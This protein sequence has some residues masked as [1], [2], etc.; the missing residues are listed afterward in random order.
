MAKKMHQAAQG[1]TFLT[2]CNIA[3]MPVMEET[4]VAVPQEPPEE[5]TVMMML[6]DINHMSQRSKENYDDLEAIRRM[7]NST[8]HNVNHHIDTVSGL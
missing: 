3:D 4:Q 2:G 5:R 6:E 1:G 8:G 7:V